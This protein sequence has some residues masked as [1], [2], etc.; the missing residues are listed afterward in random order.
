[1]RYMSTVLSDCE[2]NKPRYGPDCQS[3]AFS[4]SEAGMLFAVMLDLRVVLTRRH[5]R[6]VYFPC[7]AMRDT[8]VYQRDRR[9]KERLSYEFPSDDMRAW[10]SVGRRAFGN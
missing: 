9:K 8:T 1:M 3:S 4:M 2:T 5:G 7:M 10:T 6:A